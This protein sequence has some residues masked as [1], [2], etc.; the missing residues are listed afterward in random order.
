MS[1]CASA[2]PMH[3]LRLLST[4]RP[5]P[6]SIMALSLS[7]CNRRTSHWL[8]DSLGCTGR[9]TLAALHPPLEEPWLAPSGCGMQAHDLTLCQDVGHVLC[10]SVW[11]Q[12]RCSH[13]LL[14][15]RFPVHMS[16]RVPFPARLRASGWRVQC[17]ELCLPTT[18]SVADD[19]YVLLLAERRGIV[20][21]G[22]SVK[23]LKRGVL[24]PT[25]QPLF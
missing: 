2:L 19:C 15:H 10:P 14:A 16:A 12:L 3:I 13:L 8:H 1:R 6:Q 21:A 17:E 22:E 25:C 9:L 24:P 4:I 23:C 11:G 7:K 20:A 18:R 5:A